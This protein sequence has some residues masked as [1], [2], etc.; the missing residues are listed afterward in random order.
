MFKNYCRLA[1]R[2]LSANRG[3]TLINII[4]LG[5]G[6]SVCLFILLFIFH[7]TSYDQQQ[8]GIER[9]YRVGTSF[10]SKVDQSAV[11]S[12]NAQIAAGLKAEMPEVEQAARLLTT[13][14]GSLVLD[15]TNGANHK[16]FYEKKG[17][18][19]DAGFLDLFKYEWL[20]GD[21]KTALNAPNTAVVSAELATRL[22]GRL[23]PMGRTFRTGAFG[24]C[25]FTIT[26]VFRPVGPSHIDGELL[27]NMDNEDLRPWLKDRTNWATY[28]TFLT[29]IRLKKGTDV[30]AF[31]QKLN[32]FLRSHG[33]ADITAAGAERLLF[34]QP[35]KDIHLHTESPYD[36]DISVNISK[37]YLYILGCIALFVL[38][39]ACVNF[40]NLATARSQRRAK[41]V[42]VRKVMGALRVS[43]VVQF[44]GESL[45][46]S[47]ISLGLALLLVYL[48]LPAFNLLVQ[49]ELSLFEHPGIIGWIIG[50]ALFT[51][52]L[53]GT[54]PALYLS[55]FRPIRV[56]K[57]Q[58][59][60]SLSALFLRK[61]L[62]VFQFTISVFLILAS[63]LIW[64][65][66][67]FLNRHDLG[68]QKDQQLVIPLRTQQAQNNFEALR[69]AI[70][71]DPHVVS[72]A[73]GTTYPG[74]TPSSDLR[75]Y[76][77]G[78]SVS[79]GTNIPFGGVGYNFLQTLGMTITSGRAFS[80]EFASDSN[81]II[82]NET[83]IRR[84]G[85]DP[86]TAVG[87]LLNFDQQ[88]HNYKIRVVGIVRDFNFQSLREPIHPYGFTLDMK[89]DFLFAQVKTRDYPSLISRLSAVWSRI[90]PGAPFEY[91][92]MDQDFQRT[93]E[94]EYRMARIIGVFTLFT[95]VIACLGLFGLAAFSAEQRIR[96]IGIRKVLGC[97]LAGITALLS[98][99]F[100]RLVMIAILIAS[101]L[102]WFAMNRWLQDF[103]YRVPIHWWLF[104]IAGSLAVG[105]ALATVCFQAIKAARMSPVKSLRS[106]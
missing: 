89:N 6:L 14:N 16:L 71:K 106:E 7:E 88:R 40:M 84:L 64:Q 25:T 73:G 97:S 65:Q 79:D 31:S 26:G 61:G 10:K 5:V 28:N 62:V 59:V 49:R 78:Q 81:G 42:G 70:G 32:P 94:Q 50:L 1:W 56:L 66:L 100:I 44:L 98:K 19:V 102:A 22:F 11:V 20:Q 29:Y 23:D 34:L 2:N 27:L 93:Y 95:I 76:R 96:E 85:L 51:G 75:F 99:D 91:S 18:Y 17:Y 4:G 39:I 103:S 9:L 67:D 30:A 38:V 87:K 58:L 13:P 105:I 36:R 104:V 83:A 77:E 57:G 54:Y 90:N 37:S 47:V 43:L 63:L 80:R 92:F 86:Q 46:I 24:S 72:M 12:S 35:V 15:Y 60:N 69:E 8:P 55:S 45:F 82:F 48:F 3:Y 33:S 52:L 101:P 21:P 41:E 68:F 74:Q 53:A